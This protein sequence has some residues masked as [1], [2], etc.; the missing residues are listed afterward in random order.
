MYTA[1]PFILLLVVPQALFFISLLVLIVFLEYTHKEGNI[2]VPSL[3]KHGTRSTYPG[4]VDKVMARTHNSSGAIADPLPAEPEGG[5]SSFKSSTLA[6]NAA[7]DTI[8][9]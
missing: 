8:I 5:P 4:C 9:F 6:L 2:S 1:F 3:N 7:V